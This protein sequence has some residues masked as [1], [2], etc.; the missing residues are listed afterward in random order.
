MAFDVHE[1]SMLILEAHL[2][3]FGHVNNA[4]Y[5]EIFEQARWDWITSGGFG[6][7]RIRAGGLGP[8]VLECAVRFRRELLNRTPIVVRSQVTSYVGKVGRMR[9]TIQTGAGDVACDADFVMGLFDLGK[10]KLIEPTPEWLA[11][12]GMSPADWQPAESTRGA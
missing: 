9:Q 2:D 3:T 7:D 11:C 1:Y 6:L 12:V 8:V 5:L 4:T 10:R